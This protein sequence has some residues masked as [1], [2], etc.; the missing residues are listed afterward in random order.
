M[1]KKNLRHAIQSSAWLNPETCEK[2][3]LFS[4]H[5]CHHCFASLWKIRTLKVSFL[6]NL[7][8]LSKS[9]HFS[10]A[11]KS[12]AKVDTLCHHLAICYVVR[13]E[14]TE[15]TRLFSS[16]YAF[17]FDIRLLCYSDIIGSFRSRTT[18]KFPMISRLLWLWHLLREHVKGRLSSRNKYG[19]VAN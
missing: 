5:V 15:M 17:P 1:D 13:K 18:Q 9:D 14:Q 12:K 16:F 4:Q 10:Y 19:A 3:G 7:G 8:K 2:L 11:V 6:K